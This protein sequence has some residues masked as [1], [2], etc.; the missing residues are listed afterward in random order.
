M[1][2]VKAKKYLGQHF[3]NN[4]RD[5]YRVNTPGSD[6]VRSLRA[7]TSAFRKARFQANA[8][9]G[10]MLPRMTIHQSFLEL[11]LF[12]ER[13]NL[14]DATEPGSTVDRIP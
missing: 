4:D 1:P 12:R 5:W 8:E 11:A 7:Q 6:R 9:P 10:K 13:L 2:L 3:I 14:P